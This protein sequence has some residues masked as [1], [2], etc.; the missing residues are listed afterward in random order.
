[1]NPIKLLGRSKITE[2]V[3]TVRKSME[4]ELISRAIQAREADHYV[5]SA[6]L[7]E[8]AADFGDHLV[9]RLSES[10]RMY[11]KAKD[12]AKAEA[13]YL[14]ILKAD[15]N[16]VD[17]CF[18]LANLYQSQKKY[19]E[20]EFFYERALSLRSDWAAPQEGLAHIG[21]IRAELEQRERQIRSESIQNFVLAEEKKDIRNFDQRIDSSLFKKGWDELHQ[22]HHP[23]FV[24]TRR[25]N[26][27]KTEW[28][29]GQTLR[30]IEALRG[31]LVSDVP[32]T[33]IYIYM[34]GKLI[35][36][37]KLKEAPQKFERS[38]PNIRKWAYNAWIDFTHVPRGWHHF[39]FC[40]FGV[41]DEAVEGRNWMRDHLIVADPLPEG[42]FTD[43][44]AIIAPF[45][46]D[47]S[48]S[49][50]EQINARPSIVHKASNASFPGPI[51]TVAVLR[52]DQL[53]DT[54]VST[55][56]FLRLRQLLPDAKIVG[57]MSPA[58]IDLARSYGIFDEI[59]EL[60]FPEEAAQRQRV[61]D[62]NDQEDL[63]R[64]LKA[65]NFDLTID[66]VLS[67]PSRSL[68]ALTGAPVTMGYGFEDA[69]T[70]ELD[71]ITHDPIS[72]LDFTHH[73][74]RMMLIV[75]SLELWLKSDAR[76]VRRDD[77]PRSLLTNYGLGENEPYVLIHSGSRIKFSQWPHYG[78]LAKRIVAELGIRV[79][80]I[81]DDE[82]QRNHFSEEELNGKII[83][84]AKK[85]PFD[86]FDA[87]ISYASVF[88]G[89]DSGPKHLAGLRGTQVVSLHSSR[90]S[91][92]EWGQEQTG[93][94]I[95]RQVPCAGCALHHEPDECAQDI[96]C[97]RH[98]K[99]EE[100]FAEVKKLL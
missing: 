38:N 90:I 82:T 68:V 33:D 69:K 75:R 91:W 46:P 58:C 23:A 55:A 13:L 66:F 15:P 50:V 29:S 17:A 19:D 20:A 12:L 62:I 96:A 54:V 86:H 36:S 98:I 8:R 67:G 28:G 60:D 47:P 78:Q 6:M 22:D 14:R 44:D 57:I 1:M 18:D 39:I 87:L 49:L 10:A 64:K 89:N 32:L 21:K 94:I 31:F 95:S 24:F 45:E 77:L 56:A 88:V 99:V 76:V 92:I 63:I 85:L 71:I 43:S 59:I 16:N 83:F 9:E 72:N 53:G 35:Y 81:A 4:A 52:S 3:P 40:A 93:V 30:G 27:Q 7:F 79:V 48:R 74:V 61:M 70:F 26:F 97:V 11:I 37:G 2:A 42:F 41:N 5:V 100:V 65:Y 34:D 73:S 80:F 25:G 51:R 84:L